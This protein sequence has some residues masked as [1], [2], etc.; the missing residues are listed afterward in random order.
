MQRNPVSE[1][2]HS[3]PGDHFLSVQ[4]T[5]RA[6]KATR[7]GGHHRSQLRAEIQAAALVEVVAHFRNHGSG[8]DYLRLAQERVAAVVAVAGPAREQRNGHRVGE[9]AAARDGSDEHVLHH[10]AAASGRPGP[11]GADPPL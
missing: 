4:Q 8:D 2:Q 10:H 9:I 1:P 11:P 7:L 3:H 6:S 5:R